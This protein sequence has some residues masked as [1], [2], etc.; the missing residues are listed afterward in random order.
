[1]KADLPRREPEI[2]GFWQRIDVYARI[3]AAA[4]GRPRYVLHDGPPYAN[5]PIHLGHAL[6]KVLKD[7][8]VKSRS[9]M[10]F[11]ARYVPGWD[12]HGLPI[13]HR[14][15]RE[16]RESGVDRTT[17]GALQLRERCRAHAERYV[18]VQRGEFRRLGVFW[19]WATDAR[20][21]AEAAPSRRA[22]Y[23]TLDRSYEAEIVRQLG[24]FFVRGGVYHGVKPVHWCFACRTAL[25]EAEVTYHPRVD[26]S[27][28]VKLPV[29]GLDRR[30]EAL[31]GRDVA[32]VIWTTTPWT[33][34]ANLAVALHPDLEYVAV[35]VAG[36]ALIVAEA[37]LPE[38]AARLGWQAPRVLDRFTGRELVGEGDAW[39]GDTV[40]VRR[41]YPAP[42]GPGARDGVLVLGE[43]VTLGR[44]RRGAD[45]EADEPAAEGAATEAGTGVVH[46]A[47]GHGAEDFEVG[48]RY[49]LEPFNPVGDDG[50]FLEHEVGPD[51]L[52]GAF[53]LDANRAI[54][55]DLRAR[56]LLLRHEDHPHAYPHCWRCHNPVLFR[57]TPQWFIS[58]AA[59]DLRRKALE[60]IHASR[61]LPPSGE[62]RIARLVETRPDWCISRQRSWGV[63]LP[64]VVCARCI[65]EHPDAFLR[66][67]AFFD[68]VAR[69]FLDEGSNAWFGMADGAGGHR[70]YAS[71]AERLARLVPAAVACPRCGRRDALQ[72]H[73]HIVD[74]WFESGVSHSAVLGREP[75]LPWPADLYLEGHDQ[76]RGWF[77]SSLLVAVND[78]EHAPYRAVVTHG[79]TLDG[80]GHKMSKSLGNVISPLDVAAARGAEILRLWVSMVDFLEDMRLSPEILERN[81]EAYRKVRNTFRYLLGNLHGFDP[82]ADA[83]AYPALQ[84]IDRWALQRLEQLRERCVAAYDAHQYHV[85]YHGVH[86]FCSVTLSAFYLDVLKDRLYTMPP[87][88]AARRSAQTVLHRLCSALARLV[89][90]ILC[91]TADEVWQELETLEGRTAWDGSSVHAQLFPEPL[92]VPCDGALLERWE[93]LMRYREEVNKALEAARRDGRIHASLEAQLAIQADDAADLAFLRSFGDELRFLFLASGVVFDPVGAAA[94]RSE[95]VPGLAVEVRAAPG[96]K[97]ERC[98]SY[99]LDVGG[100]ADWPGICARCAR[101]VREILSQ[102]EPA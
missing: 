75:G 44:A 26:P 90:P 73:E 32:V 49:G 59:N 25:A 81:A 58:M 27:I 93:R 64:A 1:M 21:E 22:I 89:A 17:L 62:E 11:D 39:V 63:P 54:V 13:E 79:F 41:P 77:H 40:A 24:R 91:F 14:V 30:R 92:E 45:D 67:P 7:F 38:T 101:A 94:F 47:P 20:E 35:D 28:W 72:F 66:E 65:G 46:T 97:C 86:Q 5:D 71:S 8:V 99:A 31:R 37:L 29:V 76:Y 78:R 102:A 18:E 23:R 2:L 34:P 16:L 15:D 84:E 60:Q 100:D 70:P 51:W 87:R 95:L 83:L 6:N 42:R 61:W 96:A 69:L 88:H 43:H 53:V 56:G 50:R 12:C 33:L 36:E 82:R 52:R 4:S 19:D 80:R 74:V 48:Q 55:E 85:V 3:R 9:M 98:W 10:G 68:H 57:A